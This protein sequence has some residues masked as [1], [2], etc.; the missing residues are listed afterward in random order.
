MNASASRLLP[1]P[2][3]AASQHERAAAAAR[4][5]RQHR[6][7]APPFAVAADERHA[8]CRRRVQRAQLPDALRRSEALDGDV[9]ERL[10]LDLR[11]DGAVH[12]V[13]NRGLTGFRE[14]G[15][16]RGEVDGVAGHRVRAVRVAAG[17]R[18]DDLTARDADVRR[19][20]KAR[21]IDD[22]RHAGV[23]VE[24][25]A[26][27]ALDVVPVRDRRA[28]D[29]HH[30][31]AD[32]LVDRAAGALDRAVGELEV[33]REDPMDIL[34]VAP[35]RHPCVAGEIGEQDRDLPALAGGCL[36]RAATLGDRCPA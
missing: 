2:G 28:E 20:R 16:P 35:A 33:T 26:Q 19:E 12:V 36:R 11:R 21:R 34:G 17:C 30:R 8:R 25:G 32:V 29:A 31:V 10:D 6:R 4:D 1:M 23:D 27:C 3:S 7:E 9:A 14:V 15:E 18:C 13:G 22:R 24:R 5:L